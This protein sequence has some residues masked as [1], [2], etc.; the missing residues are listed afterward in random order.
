MWPETL[1]LFQYYKGIVIGIIIGLGFAWLCW[2]LPVH[3]RT[4][5]T[6]KLRKIVLDLRRIEAA[7]TGN[8]NAPNPRELRV[9]RVPLRQR[10]METWQVR[11]AAWRA[12]TKPRTPEQ[13]AQ[14]AYE[15]QLME[16]T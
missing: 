16:A 13:A 9:Q 4:R 11:C 7:F 5:H 1:E 2:R 6:R 10:M 12:D 3:L 15:R 14:E 8:R